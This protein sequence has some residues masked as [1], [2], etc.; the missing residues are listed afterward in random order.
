[1]QSV[2]SGISPRHFYLIESE[3]LFKQQIEKNVAKLVEYDE[4]NHIN[5]FQGTGRLD[6]VVSGPDDRL[7]VLEAMVQNLLNKIAWLEDAR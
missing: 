3:E 6:G 7:L 1:M 2:N 4:N 5:S